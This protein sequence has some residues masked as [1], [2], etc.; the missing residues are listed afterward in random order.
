[1]HKRNSAR[2]VELNCNEFPDDLLIMC[3]V[4]KVR[5]GGYVYNGVLEITGLATVTAK[6]GWDKANVPG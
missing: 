2:E 4:V 3:G 6:S 1:M 5:S